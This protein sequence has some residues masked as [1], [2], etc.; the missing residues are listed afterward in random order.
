VYALAVDSNGNLYVGG[1]F[2]TV[3]NTGGSVV[4]ANRIAKWSSSTW[5]ALGNGTSNFV[6]ALVVDSNNNLYVGGLFTLIG[7]SYVNKIAKIL[8]N[9]IINISINNNYSTTLISNQYLCLNY[10]KQNNRFYNAYKGYL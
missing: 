7:D 10:F 1:S 2:A 8:T 9:T 6:Y 5:S 4:T 3:T